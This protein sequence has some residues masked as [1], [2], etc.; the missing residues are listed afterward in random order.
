MFHCNTALV[1]DE[2]TINKSFDNIQTFRPIV[3]YLWESDFIAFIFL[4][5]LLRDT[6]ICSLCAKH[7]AAR[8]S[9]N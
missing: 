9:E 6:E 4:I 5:F 7:P 3:I 2:L 1:S 8:L